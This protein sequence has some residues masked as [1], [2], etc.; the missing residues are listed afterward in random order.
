MKTDT[1]TSMLVAIED[2]SLMTV[3]GGTGYPVKPLELDLSLAFNHQNNTITFSHNYIEG[4]GPAVFQFTQQ[5]V[6]GSAS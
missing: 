5:N 6:N 3:A 2:D 1:Q 4:A